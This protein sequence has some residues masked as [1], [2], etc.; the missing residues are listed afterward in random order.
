LCRLLTCY[1]GKDIGTTLLGPTEI[2]PQRPGAF[3][4]HVPLPV[5]LLLF[6]A[7][8]EIVPVR[9][10]AETLGWIVHLFGH[11]SEIPEDL[12]SD[13]QTAALVMTHQFGRD[14]AVLDRLLP[15]QVPYVG[16]LGP[17]NRYRQIVGELYERRALDPETL[18][19]IH[20]PAGLD[21]GSETPEEIALSIVAE[22]S[23]VLAERHGGHLREKATAIH[24]A[25]GPEAER[26]A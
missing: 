15:L 22:V 10:F 21:I 7:G 26:V 11:P 5:R 17:R 24:I 6:G 4:H 2:V 20:A 23:A 1:E 18:L 16:L 12:A 25:S 9:Q 8:P 14:L 3:L 13:A 19:P